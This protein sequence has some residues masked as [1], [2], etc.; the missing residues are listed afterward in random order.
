MIEG[1]GIYSWDLR[2][3]TVLCNKIC[4]VIISSVDFKGQ[5]DQTDVLIIFI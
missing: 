3:N 5:I 4:I 1:Q 2:L